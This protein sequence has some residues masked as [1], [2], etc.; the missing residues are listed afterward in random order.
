[1]RNYLLSALLIVG[2]V[3]FGNAQST[4]PYT[5][6]SN[7]IDTTI[8]SGQYILEGTLTHDKFSVNEAYISSFS[9]RWA[10]SGKTG[11]F[12]IVLNI[13][14]SVVTIKKYGLNDIIFISS[15]A[16]LNQH[17]IVISAEMMEAPK[18]ISLKPVIYAYS[19]VPI[20][21]DLT[22][23]PTGKFTFT[24]PQINVNNTWV[25]MQTDQ[26]GKLTDA[27]GKVFPYL[28]WESVNQPNAFAYKR[29]QNKWLGSVVEQ[30]D[31]VAF[32]ER[33]L[34]ELGLTAIEQTDFITFWGP[35]MTHYSACFVQ[36]LVDEEYDQVASLT[37]SPAPQSS[38]R[39]YLLY[40]GMETT[41]SQAQFIQQHAVEQHFP[42]FERKGF[43][44]L[45]WGGSELEM[46]CLKL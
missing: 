1:M 34:T 27:Q 45:E 19:E 5:I 15:S 40:T 9:G 7:D 10:Q 2:H 6:V 18:I 25:G 35:R 37:C 8:L 24:Y 26:N 3:I 46:E 16:Q 42:A 44:L 14:D 13:S 28:F 39:V 4:L 22:I 30:K 43:T 41:S 32:L 12:K 23:I 20:T 17:R 31:L 33:K 11:K 36:F 21:F 29:E 38:R